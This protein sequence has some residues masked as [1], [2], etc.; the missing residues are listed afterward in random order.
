MRFGLAGRRFTSVG[1]S[2]ADEVERAA[3]A[4]GK[5]GAALLVRVRP[6]NDSIVQEV[7]SRTFRRGIE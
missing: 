2:A 6:I 1:A 5:T 7:F 4:A 3:E